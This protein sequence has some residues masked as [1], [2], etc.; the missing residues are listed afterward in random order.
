MK[1]GNT[2]DAVVDDSGRQVVRHYL[3]D[4]GSTFGTG[5]NGPR[6]YDEGWELLY[7]PDL[8]LKRLVRFGFVIKPWQTVEYRQHPAIGR[9]EGDVFDPPSWRPRVATAAF[10]HARADDSFWAARRVAAFSDEMIRAAVESGRY[11]DPAAAALLTNVLIKR[12]QKIAAAYLPA[13]N[14]LV[15]FRLDDGGRL[16]FRN[17]AVDAAVARPPA[18]YRA[19]WSTYD[20]AT[21]E[22]RPLGADATSAD[23]ALVSP[24]PLPAAEGAFVRVQVTAQ[25]PARAEW[26]QPV[27]VYFTRTAGQWRLVGLERQK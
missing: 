19:S 18:G 9:F 22:S 13:I 26:T 10:H 23:A 12:R 14:P 1:A 7:T 11:T 24:R 21:G 8:L 25:A 4:V 6:E 17:A 15:D 2:L 27:E 3:Q 5:A 20:N 16:T